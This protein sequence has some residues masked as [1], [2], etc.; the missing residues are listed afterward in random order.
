MNEIGIFG[1]T[2]DPPHLGHIVCAKHLLQ[3][4]IIEKLLIVPAFS[5]P[6]KTYKITDFE[7]RLNMLKLSF[8]GISDIEF[9]TIERIL[10]KP[11]YSYITLRK[12]KEAHPNW[13][14]H[15]IIGLDNLLSI[16]TW[17]NYKTLI[18][19]NNFILINRGGYRIK[20][21]DC[22]N[23]TLSEYNKLTKNTIK[24]PRLNISSTKLREDL[25]N[26]KKTVLK[27]LTKKVFEYIKD[28]KLYISGLKS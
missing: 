2:F 14:M 12:L 6:H 27:H 10:R 15:F 5:P 23:L 28:N 17:K 16:H 20:Y 22:K 11:N 4:R 9:S 25:F 3:T 24:T 26:N 1:G 7:H 19:E 13:N 21:L 8:E 18:K